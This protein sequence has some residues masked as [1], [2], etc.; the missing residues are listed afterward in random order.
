MKEINKMTILVLFIILLSAILLSC[1]TS[2]IVDYSNLNR[3]CFVDSTSKIDKFDD[4]SIDNCYVFVNIRNVYECYIVN[5][6]IF[7]AEDK[8][9]QY[10]LTNLKVMSEDNE[11]VYEYS[12]F[13][14]GEKKEKLSN[15]VD[16][17]SWDLFRLQSVRFHLQKFYLL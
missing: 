1:K 17:K 9:P 5:I 14:F 10:Q 12:L 15:V 11:T 3:R 7:Q 2:S 8:L 6:D 13:D 16:E 4:F